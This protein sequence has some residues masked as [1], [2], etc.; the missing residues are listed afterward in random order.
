[1]L[2][3]LTAHGVSIPSSCH[4]GICQTCLMQA[5]SGNIPATAHP[6]LKNSLVAQNYFL[7]CSFHP[8]E[9][10]Q[11]RLPMTGLGKLSATVAEIDFLNTQIVRLKLA[12][13]TKFNYKAGQFINLFKDNATSRAYSLASVPGIDDQ[14]QFHIRKLPDGLV[15]HWVHH[16]LKVG[17]NVDISDA[18]GDCFYVPDM[19]DQ[20][21]LLIATGT[22]LAPLYGIVRDAL[23]Q[24]HSGTIKLYHGSNSPDLVYL[25]EELKS[26]ALQFDHFNYTPCISGKTVPQG[27]AAGRAQEVAFKENQDLS[28]WR[29]FLCGHPKMVSTGKKLAFLAGASTGNIYADPFVLVPRSASKTISA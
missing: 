28:G 17:D 3:C 16:D 20:K 15:S 18:S 24:G 4:A 23:F 26:L 8:Q 10:V 9:D 7:A 12:L 13:N 19:P 22:G 25:S 5:I 27:F 21:L 11:I 2:D 14:L 29:V 6:G 1:M